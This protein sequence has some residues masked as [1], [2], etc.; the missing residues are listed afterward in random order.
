[1]VM[2]KKRDVHFPRHPYV[3]ALSIAM[4]GV[5]ATK[6]GLRVEVNTF[7]TGNL[8]ALTLGVAAN[9]L[10]PLV[11]HLLE[12][13]SEGRLS[14]EQYKTIR[15]ATVRQK[16]QSTIQRMELDDPELL[17]TFF[18]NYLAGVGLCEV[19]C[20]LEEALIEFFQRLR[21]LI[22]QESGDPSKLLDGCENTLLLSKQ[23][24][25][26]SVVRSIQ[27]DLSILSKYEVASIV[28]RDALFQRVVDEPPDE[29]V[30]EI[31]SM[32]IDP[33]LLHGPPN[34]GKTCCAMRL[35]W[36]WKKK[37]PGMPALYLDA[38]LD[39]PEQVIQLSRR[40]SPQTDVLYVI[41]D[42]HYASEDLVNW[43]LSMRQ[44]VDSRTTGFVGILWVARDS[45]IAHKLVKSGK[46]A[47]EP[48]PIERTLELFTKRL[49][50]LTLGQR[51]IAA[52]ETGLDPRIA[53]EFEFTPDCE[54]H[55]FDEF[56]QWLSKEIHERFY[57]ELS[58]IRCN[59]GSEG[60]EVY[61]MLLPFG[62]I[63]YPVEEGFL[64]EMGMSSPTSMEP[65]RRHGR[66]RIISRDQRFRVL[67]TEHPFQI[68][69]KLNAL[70]HDRAPDR[71][72][73]AIR[74]IY[75]DCSTDPNI[76][77]AAFTLYIS[78]QRSAEDQRSLIRELEAH[79]DWSGVPN[80]LL[81]GLRFL[82][83]C[84]GWETDK[85][86][87]NSATTLY[88]KLNR[89][90]YR[91]PECEFRRSLMEDRDF[92]MEERRVA[93]ASLRC[94]SGNYRLDHIL[95]EI[96]YID[97]LLE[98]YN[99]AKDLFSQSVDASLAAIERGMRAK[100]C[101]PEWNDG[102]MSFANIW[103]AAI[104]KR[105][106]RVR[107]VLYN[108]ISSGG[109]SDR[110]QEE[111]NSLSM[112][113]ALIHERLAI[114]NSAAVEGSASLYIEA[115]QA[116]CP[117]WRPPDD[118]IPYS[119]T[120]ETESS[121]RRHELNTS[122]NAAEMSSWPALFGFCAIRIPTKRVPHQVPLPTDLPQTGLPLYI[123]QQADLVY[124]WAEGGKPEELEAEV[125]NTAALM[126]A[127]DGYI[128]FG[129]LLLLAWRCVSSDDIA[130]A[131]AWYL[132]NRVPDAGCNGLPKK[133]LR[134]LANTGQGKLLRK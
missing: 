1:M 32:L 46:V 99:E 13:R 117:E 131:L 77:E 102:A 70:A 51:I 43:V 76:P 24:E 73:D 50:Q 6:E 38:K 78:T 16:L 96:A 120:P 30:N 97:Y 5:V 101:T 115:L 98:S 74:R 2:V 118:G 83:N 52:F 80:P 47:P 79:A 109:L 26:L 3:A 107:E 122:L 40:I 23:R 129:D 89:Y 53:R 124:R 110:T 58:G 114:A 31:L 41:D 105:A 39:V 55:G 19:D 92:W 82:L 127:A 28:Q 4:P 35:A 20:E 65:L 7:L 71:A 75:P 128:R 62:S 67:L 116:V 69:R 103:V 8:W 123:T 34:V 132:E 54:I 49:Q 130:G 15:E 91:D 104:N 125:I 37:H 22:I 121:L 66:A 44:V 86:T 126:R 10:T 60:Y 11:R 14:E 108:A 42:I 33:V 113:G 100:F 88:L 57:P 9:L 21:I 94:H 134:H 87:K 61:L 85:E 90:S 68:Q 25:I 64:R 111:L 95:Y 27:E 18:R 29:T 112:E 119:R 72:I 48:F 56:A 133:A 12:S 93:E 45:S 59:L 63:S 84:A 36:E 106:A 17:R 81:Q